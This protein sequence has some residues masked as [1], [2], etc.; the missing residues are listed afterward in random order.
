V[1]VD[2]K[3]EYH[4]AFVFFP[5]LR[6]QNCHWNKGSENE[7]HKSNEDEDWDATAPSAA[8]FAV[9]H[10]RRQLLNSLIHGKHVLDLGQSNVLLSDAQSDISNAEPSG[11]SIPNDVFE[12]I[13]YGKVPRRGAAE[14]QV[15]FM[16]K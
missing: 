4:G 16:H 7:D 2:V 5:F 6:Q 3:R 13:R 8:C 1:R 15:G 11:V 14:P 12:K 9:I 10:V